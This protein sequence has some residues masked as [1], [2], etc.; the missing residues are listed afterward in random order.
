MIVKFYDIIMEKCN[1]CNRK[2][3]ID[4][5]KHTGWCNSNNNIK[6]AKVMIHKWEEPIISGTKGSG[7]IFFSNCNL[8]CVFCQ[9]YQISHNGIGKEI[10]ISE[11]I[12]IIKFLEGQSVNNI[13]LVTPTHYSKQI[14]EAL[15]IY[16]PKIPIVW[17]TNSY[18]SKET[19]LELVK[20]VD[21][22]LFDL[23]YKDSLIS[24]KYSKCKDYFDIASQNI[25]T[26]RKFIKN[27]IIKDGIMQKGLII[28]HLV[29][30]SNTDDS[31]NILNWIK[32][33]L[34]HSLVSI[35]SQYTPYYEASKYPEINRKLKPLEYKR[36]IT[37]CNNLN[38][39]GFI[40]DIS[41]ASE[42]YI[43]DFELPINIDTYIKTDKENK[44]MTLEEIKKILIEKSEYSEFSAEM[45]AKR[46][47]NMDIECFNAFILWNKTGKVKNI[48][49]GNYTV[50]KLIHQ[51]GLKI[52]AA[53]LALSDLKSNYEIVS[54]I[55]ERGNK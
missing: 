35:M 16:R 18:E 22:F 29:L 40:Q 43:P 47:L 54:Q 14:I 45:T 5:N 25:L 46:I 17:N 2:C 4:R 48:E 36:V 23:K 31:I 19:M 38:L 28:R 24:E 15:K 27:D 20:Y 49:C 3:N 11:F 7:A 13:N 52:P 26:A 55:I 33:N 8:K 51:H 9:N 30:P 34:P 6:I 42:E 32:K 37:H 10:T 50:N 1:L 21:I 41:S 44:K 39:D 12:D 53:F